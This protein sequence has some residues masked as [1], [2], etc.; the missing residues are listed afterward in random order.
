MRCAVLVD[1]SARCWGHNFFGALGN[2]DSSDDTD[3]PTPQTVSALTDAKTITAGYHSTCALLGAGGVMCWGDGH[4][5]NG[6][7]GG[8]LRVPVSV[9]GVTTAVALATGNSHSCVALSS[10]TA[11]CW[12]YGGEFQLGDGTSN[13]GA[14]PV[15]VKGFTDVVAVAAG[16]AFSCALRSGGTA[17][18]WGIDSYGELGIGTSHSGT[19]A[20][21]TP[22]PVPGLSNAVAITAGEYHTCAALSNATMMCWGENNFGQLGN[23]STDNSPK[24]I[25]VVG[26]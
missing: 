14:S 5:G 15:T 22:S 21:T 12:G 6:S 20:R 13:D 9:V 1:G 18:C 26:L 10:G 16:D 11:K 2:N 17:L 23:G 4:A 25:A 3:S 24:P 8:I 19:E 7:V